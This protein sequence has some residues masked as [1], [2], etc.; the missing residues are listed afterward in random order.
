MTRKEIIT[1][2]AR[3]CLNDVIPAC[4]KHK[5]A[6]R[7]FLR[8]VERME[9]E[10]N[11]PYYWDEDG[12]DNIVSW[13]KN[14][15]H[16]KG[17]LAGQPI[18]LT[19][20]QQFHLCQLYGWK[21]KKDDRRRFKKMFIEVSRKNAKSQELAGIILYEMSVTATKN[22]ELA[23]IYT[24][25]TKSEQSRICFKEA[26][27]MLNGSKLRPKFKITKSSIE[28][29]KSGSYV[30]PLSKDDGKNGDGTNPAVLVL[31]EYHQHKT[32]EFYDLSI[33][34]N[35]KEPL[36]CIITTAGVDL[37]VPCKREYDF[38]SNIIDPNV[39]I[40]DEEYLIDICEQ[41]KDEAEDPRLLMDERRW[42]KSNPIRATYP[43]GR[44]KIRTTYEKAL[45][46]PEDMP[47]VLTKNFDI[48][49]QAK[50]CGYMDMKKWKS[51]EVEELPV[52]IK[53]LQCVVGIDMSSKIDLTSC[54]IVIP[55]KD[56][57]ET[58]ADGE[59]V[60]KYIIFSHS[61]I[62]NREKL[63]ERVNV[64]KAPYDAWEMQGYLTITDTQIVD[65]AA[66]MVWALDF[67]KS[68]GL[69]IA[70]WAVDP[71]NASMFM[72]TLS[73]RGETVYDVTQSYGGLND[74]TVGLREEI[75][76]GNVMYQPNP[77]LSFAMGNAVIRKSN[78]LIKIDK[79]AVRQRID[80]VDA[81][82]C[83]FKLSRIIDQ[84]YVSQRQQEEAN[85]AWLEYMDKY[86]S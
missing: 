4:V 5:N 53:G 59:P 19:E 15:R 3:D 63:I 80:P 61:F 60:V 74:A 75:F 23:E 6:C 47:S 41:D 68:H 10:P 21:R 67:A 70:C 45:K 17:E 37:S 76:A 33:G 1:H 46:I 65:Q 81:L 22:G 54:S 11:Y 57:E 28:H 24:A 34:S 16:R 27:L 2:Y 40:E 30:K 79:D 12:A 35:T 7:R 43:E 8:D 44:E 49:V 32:T 69:E 84:A 31:D 51:C 64:D 83:A 86:Y 78:G 72:Q 58:D 36:L 20:W 29:I 38:C 82:I 56:T 85:R 25:G 71:A 9:T 50:E 48:W 66:V 14:L 52:D 39:D 62:P 73:D 18:N 55:Y 13:F 42:L 77:V 26:G